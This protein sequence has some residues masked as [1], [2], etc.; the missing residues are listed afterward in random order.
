MQTSGSAL[1]NPLSNGVKI[2]VYSISQ[3]RDLNRR[4]QADD[5]PIQLKI[6]KVTK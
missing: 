1:E 5:R 6:T 3:S 4:M 2:A